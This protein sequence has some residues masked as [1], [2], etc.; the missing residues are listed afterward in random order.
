MNHIVRGVYLKAYLKLRFFGLKSR[1]VEE[2]SIVIVKL[3]AFEER[4]SI[5]V[6]NDSVECIECQIL[7]TAKSLAQNFFQEPGPMSPYFPYDISNCISY[8]H[9][10]SNHQFEQELLVASNRGCLYII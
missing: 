1:A 6:I 2:S 3:Y 9:P 7:I 5:T 10:N 4:I 8:R